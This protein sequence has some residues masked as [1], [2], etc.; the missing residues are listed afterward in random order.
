MPP[1]TLVELLVVVLVDWVALDSVVAVLVS[2]AVVLVVVLASSPVAGGRAVVSVVTS[3][4]GGC[5]PPGFAVDE[6]SAGVPTSLVVVLVVVLIASVTATSLAPAAV[7]SA[8][9]ASSRLWACR[10]ALLLCAAAR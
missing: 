9:A 6:A 4:T 3:V 10:C 8:L 5:E 2:V 1:V 7:A